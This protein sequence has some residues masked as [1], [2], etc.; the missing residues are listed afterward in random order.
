MIFDVFQALLDGLLVGGTYALLA[1]GLALIFGVM[2]VINFAQAD[3]MMLAM[4]FA[5][6]LWIG[7]N[8][9]PLLVV[10]IAFVVFVIFGMI[11]HRGFVS[12]VSGRR[13]NHDAQVILTLG[14]GIV[15]QNAIL[16]IFTSSPRILRPPYANRGWRIGDIFIDQA[17]TYAFLVV[18]VSAAALWLFLQKAATG[19]AIRASSQDWE[20]ATYMGIDVER[21]HSLAFGIGIGLTAVG[22]VMLA[23][24]QPLGPFVGLEFVVVMFVAVVLGGL[25]SVSG[26]IAGGVVIG[27]VQSVSQ[28]F[29]SSQLANVWVFLLFLIILY[30]RPQGLFGRALRGV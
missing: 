2:R 9:D 7:P 27:V 25:G 3:F 16:L 13:E 17:R 20:A 12:K 23:T 19:R 29:A 1:A 6:L 8:L 10:P 26:A 14:M 21:T 22:G 4:Y 15:F 5:Y 24:F 30:V 28:V 11:A 18:I